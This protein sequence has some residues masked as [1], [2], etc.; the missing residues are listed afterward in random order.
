[1]S[2]VDVPI[3]GNVMPQRWMGQRVVR[4]AQRS[5]TFFSCVCTGGS[6]GVRRRSRKCVNPLAENLSF[7]VARGNTYEPPPCGFTAAALLC[8]ATHQN[9][10]YRS[11]L[12]NGAQFLLTHL[13]PEVFLCSF[14]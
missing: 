12:F 5:S 6:K 13:L 9:D 7:L 11:H 1:M 3:G 14:S 4:K 8:A 10:R 2:W